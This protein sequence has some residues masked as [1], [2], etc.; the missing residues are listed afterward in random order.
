VGGNVLGFEALSRHLGPDQPVYGLQ[1]VGLEGKQAPLTDVEEMADYHV[2]AVLEFQP[3]GPYLLAGQSF[4]GLVAFEMARRLRASGHRQ[5]MV[6]LFDTGV[7]FGPP[8]SRTARLARRTR[9]LIRRTLRQM[10]DVSRMSETDKLKYLA[11][12]TRTL[13]R[14]SRSRLWRATHNVYRLMA[15]QERPLPQALRSVEEGCWM[16]ARRY[17]PHA[18]DGRVILFLAEQRSPSFSGDSRGGWNQLA[19][20]GM[21]VHVIPGDHVSILKEPNIQVL[22]EQLKACMA[23]M[24]T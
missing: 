8:L 17:V 2:R 4:G 11:A 24:L 16:A 20:G 7:R 14:R 12:R 5:V 9:A 13:K 10:S 19:L 6:A 23:A 3:E 15:G 18:Y 22:A 1:A 21:E